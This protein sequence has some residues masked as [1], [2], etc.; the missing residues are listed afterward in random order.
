MADGMGIIAYVI[1]DIVVNGAK[2][3]LVVH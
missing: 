1:M 2:F 3:G